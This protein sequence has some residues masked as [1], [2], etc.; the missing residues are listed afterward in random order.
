MDYIFTFGAG[1]KNAGKCVRVSAETKEEA[2]HKMIKEYG[3]HWAFC[4][5]IEE[6]EEMKK[7]AWYKDYLEKE[8]PFGN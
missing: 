2:R 3:Y 6:W 7:D 8:I 5:P 1:H 4:Y